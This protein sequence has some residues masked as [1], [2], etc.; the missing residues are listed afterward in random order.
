MRACI[1]MVRKQEEKE[2]EEPLTKALREEASRILVR[3]LE[4][5]EK[6]IPL[7]LKNSCTTMENEG[8]KFLFFHPL[9]LETSRSKF[10]VHLSIF[11]QASSR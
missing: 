3:S 9:K 8:F 6:W 2:D 7:L 1:K 11:V 10:I 5:E 4:K